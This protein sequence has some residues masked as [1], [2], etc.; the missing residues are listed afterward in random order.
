LEAI[1]M[2]AALDSLLEA[3][4]SGRRSEGGG[5]QPEKRERC[6]SR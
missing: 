1:G 4:G 6:G 3:A 2:G 5:R